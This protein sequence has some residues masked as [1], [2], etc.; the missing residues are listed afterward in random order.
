[1]L[2]YPDTSF[3]FSLYAQDAH[4]ARAAALAAGLRTPFAFTALQRH[5]LR[6]AFRLARFRGELS[7]DEARIL[8]HTI[9]TDVRDGVLRETVVA[10]ADVFTRA[11]A[12]GA[13]HTAVLGTRAADILHVACAAAMGAHRFFSFDLRQRALATKAGL[14]VNA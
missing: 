4:T 8:L 10:W 2:V 1:M 14:K 5:E 6:N 12:L 13:A 11:E 3:L 7:A 9:E